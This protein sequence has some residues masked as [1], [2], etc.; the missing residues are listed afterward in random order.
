MKLASARAL[1][2]RFLLGDWMNAPEWIT[3]REA[4]EL[5]GYSVQYV[6]CIIRQ[7]KVKAEKR[8]GHD[9]WIDKA[10]L[11]TYV[12][13]MKSLDTEKHNAYRDTKKIDATP[14]EW[15]FVLASPIVNT[16]DG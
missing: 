5:S 15:R 2:R 14:H 10:S 1:A 11:Q 13:A 9:G 7:N 8:S 16:G 6:W 12:K 4:S 3:V